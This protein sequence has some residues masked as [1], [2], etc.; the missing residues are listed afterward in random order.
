MS[1]GVFGIGFVVPQ[2]VTLLITVTVPATFAAAAAA[3]PAT[4]APVC[5]PLNLKAS[6]SLVLIELKPLHNF[7]GSK[8]KRIFREPNSIFKSYLNVLCI[9]TSTTFGSL[10]KFEGAP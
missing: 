6:K 5:S 10:Q 8:L 7:Q 2:C 9:E 4:V 3:V 1:Q